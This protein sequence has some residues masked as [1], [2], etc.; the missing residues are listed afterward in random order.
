MKQSAQKKGWPVL[1][2]V[3]LPLIPLFPQ[4]SDSVDLEHLYMMAQFSRI[5][6][7]L[8]KSG[9]ETLSN[10]EKWL[11]IECLARNAKREEAERL[12]QKTRLEKS[13]SSRAHAAAGIMKTAF[14]QFAEAGNH[15]GQ[16]L[17]QDPV[18][19]EAMMG[20]TMLKLYLREFE[21][22]RKIHEEFMNKHP[23]WAKSYLSHL[24]GMKVYGS[25]GNIAKI[26]ESY[27]AQAEKFMKVDKKQH[28]NFRKNFRLYRR[29]SNHRAFQSK[30]T[31][32]RVVLPFIERA[33][34]DSFAV[35]ALRIEDKLYKVLLDTG[36]RAGWTIHSRELEKGLKLRKGGT[37]LTRIGTQ[38]EFLH[39]YLILTER[40]DIGELTIQYL[41]GMYVPAPH[42]DYPE[43]NLN[44]LFINDRVITLDFIEK[45]M[46]VRTRERFHQDIEEAVSQQKKIVTI[47]WYGYEQAFIPA[48]VN[49]GYEALAMVETG[50]EDITLNLDFARRSQLPL[51]PA[52]K[53]LA[54]GK[55][56]EY[57]KT[58]FRM[59]LGEIG[60]Q[61]HAADVWSMERIADPITGLTPDIILGPIF[62]REN[63][64][65]TFDPYRK[66]IVITEFSF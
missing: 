3:I 54:T 36:N 9:F 40:I 14:G 29:Q 57:F 51:E 47:P 37:V 16:A 48:V 42:P 2:A 7:I 63:Y 4:K 25:T 61:R 31:S 46:V 32:N 55:K 13:L 38:K 26:A 45:K 30:S 41:P 53:Y 66:M 15:F 20:M 17:L 6:G 11:F 23:E 64:A 19:P 33:D 50:A 10:R 43:A 59:N 49:G 65:L 44:P 35:I 52:I 60:I 12:W 58:F 39:G 24:L 5:A 62:F 18:C 1:F 56:F 28:Q 8:E 34:K 27:G 22:A 21:E